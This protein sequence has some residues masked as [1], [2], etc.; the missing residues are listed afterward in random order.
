MKTKI[1]QIF[2]KY[3]TNSI[4]FTSAKEIF[5]LTMLDFDGFWLLFTKDKIY[6]ICSRMIENQVRESFSNQ[7][8]SLVVT[9]QPFYKTIPE[10][11]RQNKI[12][13][14]LIDPKYMNAMDFILINNKL[15]LNGINII[16][17]IGVLND[18]RIVKKAE[19]IKNIKMSCNIA[20]QVCDIIRG[21]LRPGI[22]ELD[23]C[24]RVLELFARNK[25]KESFAPIIASGRN[26]ANPHHMSSERKITEDDIITID[27]GCL[28][29]G[30]C[31]DL[32]RTYFLD[33]INSR[34][35]SIWD[36]VKNSQEAVIKDI[37]AGV[38]LSW[39]DITARNIVEKA[40]Y[41]NNFIHSIGHGVGIEIHEMPLLAVNAKGIFLE[42]MVVAIEPG[43]YIEQEFGVRIEDT[44]LIKENGCEILT[45]AMY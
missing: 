32:T 17:K 42:Q 12:N 29:N 39:A 5:Y 11:L 28:Y 41:K 14:I 22:S 24:Y 23:I 9:N 26:S 25:V 18:M 34:Y 20:S 33:K 43:I 15:R 16:K 44:V 10:I 1:S 13:N 31:S 37:K 4:L 35:K 45:S 40:G 36:I 2:S 3:E 6:V 19:E 21:E 7:N 27:I 8:I 30:Y 38:L